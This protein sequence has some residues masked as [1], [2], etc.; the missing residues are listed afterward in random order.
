MSDFTWRY[1][2]DDLSVRANRLHRSR[3]V[4]DFCDEHEIVGYFKVPPHRVDLAKMPDG[5]PI[6]DDGEWNTCSVCALYLHSGRWDDLISRAVRLHSRKSAAPSGKIR[7]DIEARYAQ[8]R[9][10]WTGEFVPEASA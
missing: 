7:R 9:G 1:G 6:L 2:D 3:A 8:L 4:C 10:V 5:R